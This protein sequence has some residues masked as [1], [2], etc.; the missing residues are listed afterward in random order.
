MIVVAAQVWTYWL[1]PPLLAAAVMLLVATA[2]G[3]YRKVALPAYLAEQQRRFE[4]TRSAQKSTP[5]QLLPGRTELRA[6]DQ[7]PLAA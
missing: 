5:A 1:A 6:T 4:A 3:Y 7:M 2:I